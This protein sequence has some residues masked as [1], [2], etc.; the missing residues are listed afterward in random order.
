MM[1]RMKAL[2]L[3]S[4][5]AAASTALAQD[6]TTATIDWVTILLVGVGLFFILPWAWNWLFG[7]D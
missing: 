1:K 3:T 4:A 7:G 5:L 2:A 6:D